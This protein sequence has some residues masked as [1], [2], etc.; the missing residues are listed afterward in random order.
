VKC[1]SPVLGAPGII[2]RLA[3]V[4]TRGQDVGLDGA[5]S[6]LMIGVARV[7]GDVLALLESDAQAMAHCRPSPCWAWSDYD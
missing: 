4:R 7:V 5:F 1:G 3:G 6:F 2:K